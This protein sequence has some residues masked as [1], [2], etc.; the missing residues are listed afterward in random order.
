MNT[1]I[2]DALNLGWKLAFA[3][4]A[5]ARAGLLDSYECERR[6]VA[7]RVLA[8][9]HLAFWAEAGSGQLP[10]LMRVLA[11]LAAPLIP[12]VMVRKRLVAEA[13][14]CVSQLRVSYPC[15]PISEGAT[16]RRRSRPA[17]GQ[18]L[19]DAI[20]IAD[21]HPVG[22]HALLARP[23]VHVLLDRDAPRVD[24]LALGPYVDV[25]RLESAPG[26]GVVA[27]RPDGYI[28]LSSDTLELGRLRIWLAR[29]GALGDVAAMG[30]VGWNANA[31]L[32]HSIASERLNREC[33]G[34]DAPSPARRPLLGF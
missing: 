14:R 17:A 29:I 28:G 9:T 2:Q 1:G 24:R 27:V 26:K 21:G 13:I 33:S 11:P 10:A 3:R 32:R 18:W 25:H 23:G 4:T 5:T 34:C 22:L 31:V 8:L 19:P 30:Y 15:T 16:R 7:R 20:V 6:R 12:A